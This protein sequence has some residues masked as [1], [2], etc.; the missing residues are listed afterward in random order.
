MEIISATA[1]LL[2]V[3]CYAVASEANAGDGPRPCI[4]IDAGLDAGPDLEAAL[5]DLRWR[6]V[7]VLLT[8]GH[9]DHILGLPSYA[10]RWR[11]PV[12]IGAADHYRLVDPAAT[13]SEQLAPLLGEFVRGWEAPEAQTVADAARLELAGLEISATTAPGH[14]EGS[15]L[16]DVHDPAAAEGPADVVFT[17]DVLFAGSIGRTDLPGS[18]PSAMQATLAAIRARQQPGGLPVLPGHGPASTLGHELQANP[19]F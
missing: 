8:H 13:L 18:D 9:P 12:Y 3:N 4:L 15:T 2:G 7:A 6:P 10:G 16:Y 1:E 5:A 11:V 19:F 17:G 14:T